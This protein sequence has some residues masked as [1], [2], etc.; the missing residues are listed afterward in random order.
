M[1]SAPSLPFF[2]TGR[3][4]GT[5]PLPRSK[6]ADFKSVRFSRLYFALSREHLHFHELS[7]KAVKVGVIQGEPPSFP[8]CW[9]PE[10]NDD[11]SVQARP[12]LVTAQATRPVFSHCIGSRSDNAR[13]H[14]GGSR[15]NEIS[16][17]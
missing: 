10:F 16:R 17:R 6:D 1:V 8:C 4:S 3:P 5:Q 14:H 9:Q 2:R 13:C 12:N 11:R 7:K 15:E